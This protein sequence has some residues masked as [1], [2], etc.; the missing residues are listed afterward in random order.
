MLIRKKFR[1]EAAHRLTNSFSVRCRGIHGHSYTVEIFAEGE[2]HPDNG[3]V[4]DFGLLKKNWRLMDM[5]DHSLILRSNDVVVNELVKGNILILED[6]NP[7]YILTP[8][9]PT[10]EMMAA[11]FFWAGQQKNFGDWRIAKVRVHETETGW[12]ECDSL[13]LD[14]PFEA[15]VFSRAI[16]EE[17]E[18]RDG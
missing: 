10:A 6:F 16:R 1:F 8:Y 11:H 17:E 12:A 14:V 2:V 18:G 13:L 7:R 3:M 15:T 5:F 9:E 4:A